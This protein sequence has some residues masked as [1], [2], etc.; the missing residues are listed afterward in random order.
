MYFWD[1]F[2]SLIRAE[3]IRRKVSSLVKSESGKDLRL[4]FTLEI[5]RLRLM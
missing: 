2:A 4:R 3:R 1:E 5:L